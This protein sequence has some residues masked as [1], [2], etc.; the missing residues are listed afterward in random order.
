M[1]ASLR[2]PHPK[3]ILVPAVLLP[4]LVAALLAAP[5]LSFDYFWDDFFFLTRAQGS[6]TAYLVPNAAEAFWRPIPQGLYFRLLLALGPAG[7]LAGHL[8]NLLLLAA[9]AM[10]LASLAA[11]L[12]GPRAGLLAGLVFAAS[13]VLPS[14]VA[15]TS[16]CQDLMAMVFLLIAFHLRESGRIAASAGLA[17]LA[18]L[19]K[20]TAAVALPVLVA[21]DWLLGRK[22]SRLGSGALLF[23]IVTAAWFA[24]HPGLRALVH[25]GLQS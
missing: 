9:A 13:A 14:L 3:S 18:L 25:A 5:G 12:L 6:P 19:S 15:W 24:A 22:P 23:G 20:E 16:A 21:W 8:L 10:L 4:A 11:R 1:R 7:P 2:P 17:A